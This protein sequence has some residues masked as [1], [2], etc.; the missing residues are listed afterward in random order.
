MNF[1]QELLKLYEDVEKCSSRVVRERPDR[2]AGM[3]AKCIHCGKE[4]KLRRS[5]N[6]HQGWV[7]FPAHNSKTGV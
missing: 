2:K 4:L 6:Q 1:L 3:M 7:Q 5:M